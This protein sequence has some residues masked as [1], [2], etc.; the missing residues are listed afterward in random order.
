MN[1]QQ[2]ISQQQIETN[3]R[4][5][6]GDLQLQLIMANARIAE[7]EALLA[8]KEPQPEE[9]LPGEGKPNGKGP[10]KKEAVQ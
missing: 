3:V 4:M 2:S 10:P 1:V 6:L 5:A 8:A 7:L 9:P